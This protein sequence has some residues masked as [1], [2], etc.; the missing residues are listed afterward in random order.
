MNTLYLI[1]GAAGYLGGEVCRQM[2]TRGMKA[3]ALVLPNDKMKCYIPGEIECY[4]GDLCD[5]KSLEKFFEVPSQTETIIMHCASMVAL[6]EE[7]RELVM[8]VNVKGTMNVIDCCLQHP[9]CKKLVYVGS[10]GT[11]PELP[12]GQRMAEPEHFDETKVVGVYGQSKAIASQCVLDAVR[13]RGLKACIV[14]PSGI[15]GPGDYA[16]GTVTKGMLMQLHGETLIGVAGTFNLCDVRDLA[17]GLF[18]AAEKG[19]DGE[20][21]ILANEVVSYPEFAALSA[22]EG[23]CKKPLIYL[24]RRTATIAA[25]ILEMLAKR[26]GA[27]PALT[28]YEIYNL[29]RNN[30]FDSSKARR[31]LGYTSRPYRETIH[32]EIE[33]LHKIGKV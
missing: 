1:T 20:S 10:T 13:E 18:L 6:G 31:E 29:S 27:T 11:I 3:R 22:Q 33:W 28:R 32:D 9:E 7:R 23:N 24:S 12:H 16:I 26:K 19:K 21:Y 2:V 30:N 25:K 15:L 8:N 14:M 5:K 4:E 17:N